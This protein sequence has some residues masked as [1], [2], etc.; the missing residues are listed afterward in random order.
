MSNHQKAKLS[1]ARNRNDGS[2]SFRS[3]N[4]SASVPAVSSQFELN[5]D[6]ALFVAGVK[7]VAKRRRIDRNLTSADEF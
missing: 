3:A 4:S 7:H 6:I 2:A 5:E 1:A